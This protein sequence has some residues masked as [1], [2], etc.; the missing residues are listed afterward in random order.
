MD[1]GEV[2]EVWHGEKMVC[3]DQR[4]QLTPMALHNGKTYFTGEVCGFTD[5]S[6]FLVNMFLRRNG[7]LWARGHALIPGSMVRTNLWQISRNNAKP[8]NSSL[9]NF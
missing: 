7:D 2:S 3:G 1:D 8:L 6:F 5:S 4:Q 9:A